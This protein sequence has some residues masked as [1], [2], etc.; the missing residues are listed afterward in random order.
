M[1]T[2]FY[3]IMLLVA[4]LFIFPGCV[5]T[6][7][8]PLRA[9]EELAHA[10][11]KDPGRPVE[12]RVE[13]LLK[14]MTLAEKIG[15]MTQIEKNNLGSRTHITSYY[16]GSLLSDGGSA[17]YRN[18]P[19][20]W[21]DMY[22]DYQRE[23]L[24]TPLGI[25]LIYGYDAVHGNSK[26]QNAVIFPHNIGLGCTRDPELVKKAAEIT[27]IEVAATGVDW[28]FAPCIAVPRNEHW[29]R[30]Y[31][32]FGETPDLTEIMARAMVEGF[33]GDSLLDP[34]TILACAKHYVADG[35]TDNGVDRGNC[36]A[37]EAELRRIHLPGYKEAIGA[38][39]GSIMA[40]F[41]SWKGTLLHEHTY[42]LTD[43]LKKE[44]GFEGFVISDYKAINFISEDYYEC[45]VASINAGID[46]VMVVDNYSGFIDALEGAVE[47]KDV[48]MSR[49]DDAVRRILRVKFKL[50]LF[51]TPYTDRSYLDL[52]GS[53]KH[54]DVARECVRKSLV[55]LKNKN[56]ILPLKKNLSWIHVAGKNADDIGNQCG[57]WTITW[58]GESGHVTAGTTILEGIK[59][60]V[61]PDT[62]IT[63]SKKGKG[64]EG[65]DVAIA[66]LGELPYAEFEGDT[67]SLGLDLR[68]QTTLNHLKKAGIPIIVVLV[69]GR[70][71][72][73]ESELEN[74]DGVIAAWLPGSEG[75]GVADVLFGDYSPTGK[76]SH[77][78]PRTDEQLPINYGD[79]D[80]D[81]LFPYGYG[82]TFE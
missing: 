14:R 65:A 32:G 57:G 50:G 1:K 63:F 17:P 39:V 80:Y 18:N 40:S 56:N 58:Q 71:L 26:V 51:E 9:P 61:S 55:L 3:S 74:F 28:T 75:A 25:P 15:Q 72:L 12:E 64:A 70:P 23:A 36:L 78:W 7:V 53:E 19:K 48:K 59:A 45:V 29:G 73:L 41:S 44:L 77:T 43:V 33:Q 52:V 30:T 4:L 21:A 11:Y 20:A 54:R 46:M 60:A 16:L 49:I 5:S 76:L 6:D 31:E 66:V 62:K 24:K 22:D 10:P 2:K 27:A 68:D 34:T 47:N 69:S 37:D 35:G 81:P 42:L 13:D 79:A 82:L 8:D 38:G 67:W